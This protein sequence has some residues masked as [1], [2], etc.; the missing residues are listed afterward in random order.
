MG[1]LLAN[2]IRGINPLAKKGVLLLWAFLLSFVCVFGARDASAALAISDAWTNIAAETLATTAVNV[3]SS[4]VTVTAGVNRLLLV[5]LHMESGTTGVTA[6]VDSATF[7][8]VNL[9]PIDS[10]FARGTGRNLVWMGYLPDGSIPAGPQV[11]NFQ[12]SASANITGAQVKIASYTGVDQSSPITAYVNNTTTTTTTAFPAALSYAAGSFTVIAS[13]NSTASI[14]PSYS[15]TGGANFSVQ[16]GATSNLGGFSGNIAVSGA[17]ATAGSYATTTQVTYTGGGN[18]GTPLVAASINPYVASGDTTKPV[19]TSF[20]VP[21]SSSSLTISPITMSAS[22]DTGVVAYAITESATP[23]LPSAVTSPTTIT[24]YTASTGGTRVLYAWAKDGAGNVSDVYTSQACTINLPKKPARAVS[25]ASQYAAASYPAGTVSNFTVPAG[26]SRVLVVA[27]AATRTDIGSITVD[28]ITWGGK[29][30]TLAAGNGTQNPVWNHTFIYYL[31]EADIAA[32]SGN[33]LAVTISGGVAYYTRIY[34]SVYTGVDQTQPIDSAAFY[35]SASANSTVGPFL[36]TLTVSPQHQPIQIVNLAR[37]SVRTTSSTITSWAPGWTTAVAAPPGIVVSGPTQQVYV[38]E[39]AAT[40]ST[41]DDGSQHTASQNGTF[42]SYAAI[43]L[44]PAAGGMNISTGA[45]IGNKAVYTGDVNV[46]VDAFNIV[47]EA[48]DTIT[49]ITVTGSAATTSANVSALR[50]YR[51]TGSNLSIYEAGD[52]E[53]ASGTFSG[54]VASLTANEALAAGTARNYIIVYDITANAVPSISNT[55]TGYVSALAATN[56]SALTDPVASSAT[57]TIYPTTTI[58]N[59]VEPAAV[60]LYKASAPTN[61]DA[62]TLQHNGTTPTDDDNLSTV[63]ITLTPTGISGDGTVLSK[64]GKLEVV[65]EAG[66]VVYGSMTAATTGDIWN[67]P[68][69]GLTATSTPTNY[70][71]RIT[72][73]ANI[74]PGFY[75]VGGKI[76]SVVHSKGLSKLLNADTTSQTLT[77]DTEYPNNP[78]AFTAVTTPAAIQPGGKIDLAWT[79]AAVLDA[80]GGTLDATTPYIVKRAGTAPAEYCTDGTNVPVT[81]MSITDSGLNDTSAP[82]YHYRICAKDAQGNISNG[83][84]ASAASSFSNYCSNPPSITL[85]DEDPL[86]PGT[87]QDQLVKSVGGNPF[88]LQVT[89]NDVGECPNTTFNIALVETSTT[90]GTGIPAPSVD[91]FST[92]FPASVLLGKTAGPGGTNKTSET[93]SIYI[94]GLATADQIQKFKFKAQVTAAGHGSATSPF[95]TAVLNDMPPIVHNSNNMAKYQYGVWGNEYTCA[96]CHSNSTT[97]IKGV[98][99]VISTPIG[100]RNVVFDTISGTPATTGGYSNDLRASKD[101]SNNVCS[102]CHHRTRQ[103]Q[104]SAS[105]LFGGPANDAPYTTDHHNNRDCIKCHTHNTAFKSILGVC[106]DC[107]GFKGTDYSPVSKTTMV[108]VQTNALGTNPPSYGAHMAH[109]YAG[110]SCA[111]CHNNTNHGL[112]TDVWL[113]D[114]KLE[115]GFNVSNTTFPGFNPA[116]PVVGGTFEATT[117]L[118]YPYTWVAGPSTTINPVADYNASCTTYCHGNWS[119]NVGSG[120]KPN[121]VGTGQAACG[122]CHNATTVT[123]PV[124]GSHPTHSGTGALGL[125]KDCRICHGTYTQA[126]YTGAKHINGNVEWDLSAIS[127][128]AQYD[129]V[130]VGGSTGALAPTAPANYKT[131]TNMY[132]HSNV[133]GVGGVGAPTSYATPLW[134]DNGV[135]S[136]TVYCGS[137]HIYPNTVGGHAQHENEV[138]G[139]VCQVCHNIGGR[140]SPLNHA[141][142]KIDFEF[143]GLGQN[144]VYSKGSSVTPGLGYGTCSAS[145]CH[146]RYTRAWGPASA[147]SLCDKCHGSSTSAR[148][149]YNTKGPDGTLSIYSAAIGMHDIHIQNPNS[150]RKATFSR[151]TS[152]AAGMSCRQCHYQPDGPFYPGHMDNALPAEVPFAHVSSIAHVGDVFGYYSTPTYSFGAGTCSNV[153]CHGAGMAS[154]SSRGKYAGTTPGIVRSNPVWNQPILGTGDPCIKCHAMPPSAPDSS[155][156]HFNPGASRPFIASEC[157]NCHQHLNSTATGFVNKA[158]HINGVIDGGCTGCH[159]DPPADLGIGTETGLATPAQNALKLGTAGAHIA[160]MN[161]VNIQKNCYTCHYN[162]NPVMVKDGTG[163]LEIGFYGFGGKVKTGTFTG[164]T[165]TV[166]GPKWLANSAAGGTTTITKVDGVT[167]GQEA[168]V[169]SNLYCHGSFSGANGSSTSPNWENGSADTA[170]GSCHGASPA[171]IPLPALNGAHT[172][173]ASTNIALGSPGLGIACESCHGPS[174]A[175]MAHISGDVTWELDPNN[176]KI[177]SSAR[178]KDLAAGSTGAL[179]PSASYGSCTNFY[180]HSEVQGAGGIGLPTGGTAYKT[181]T[182]GTG[183]ALTCSSCHKDQVVTGTASHVNHTALYGGTASCGYCHHEAGD[184][185]ERHA[186][187]MI[188]VNIT[189]SKIG[190]GVYTGSNRD[191]GSAAGYG[192]CSNVI[193]HGAATITWGA[194]L[195]ANQCQKCHGS[196]SAAF[197]TV[198]SAQVAPGYGADGIATDGTTAASARRVG[199]HQRHLTTGVLSTNVKCS[200]CHVKVNTVLDSGHLNYTTATLTFSGRATGNGHTTAATSRD[201]NFTI[202]CSNLWCHT[203]KANS[204]STPVPVWTTTGMINETTLSVASCNVCHGFP[205]KTVGAGG[206]ALTFDHT[207]IAD[208]TTFPVSGCSCHANLSSTGTTYANIFSDKS[209]HLNGIIEALAGHIKKY[210]GATHMSNPAALDP[211]TNCSGCHTTWNAVGPYPAT[212]AGSAPSCRGCHTL[213]IL[214]T[215]ATSSCYDCHG[216]TATNAQPNGGVA[217]P[218]WS[219]SHTAHAALSYVCADCHLGGGTGAATHGNY[220]SAAKTRADVKV[221]FN[222]TKSGTAITYTAGTMTCGTSNCHGQKSP[223]WGEPIPAQQCRRCHGSQSVAYTGYTQATI[224]PGAGNFDTG[225]VTGNTVRGGVHQEHLTDSNGI[226]K[227]VRCVECHQTVAAVTDATHLNYTTATITF[228]GNAAAASHTPSRT[229]VSGVMNCSNVYCHQGARAE[230]TAAGQ[231]GFAS[232]PALTWNNA[233]LIDGTTVAGTCTNVCHQMPPGGAVVGDAHASLTANGTYTTPTSLQACNGCHPTINASIANMASIF[234]D[235]LKHIDGTVDGG[236]CSGCHGYDAASWATATQRATEG[237]GAHA[238]HVAYLVAK[239]GGTLNASGDQFGSGASWTNVCGVCHTGATH[240]TGEAI[241]GTARQINFQPGLSFGGSGPTYNGTVGSS[242]TV[243]SKVCFNT[244]CH[245]FTSPVWSTY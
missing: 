125:G 18:R 221:A 59:G 174:A 193:C 68:T 148:G 72:T 216:S 91:D 46:V 6:N 70:F 197:L 212:P 95:A 94:H 147:L 116:T 47:A 80:N 36:P 31:K 22:D 199:A 81:G 155:Y 50:I 187:H 23:P 107:H 223:A 236:S 67:I 127:A 226:G 185:T 7:G 103:H 89:N 97:N 146:G 194:N 141:N 10:T 8:G 104:Y 86:N 142:Q 38:R 154:N 209:Q 19:I 3:S 203:A 90:G 196:K 11:V 219:G 143:V 186:D 244:S 190:A 108:K 137:C 102:V 220:S 66:T 63:I 160:H 40:I 138:T 229:R 204:G 158:L 33:A 9:V 178:Y 245:Y 231:T 49:N 227:K 214:R 64:I 111:V 207:G 43:S 173:H 51:K 52:V 88:L 117:N 165:N 131:C 115:I 202:Q 153:W 243:K 14:T 85:G 162:Y 120:T 234:A 198:T 192:S 42:D 208:P 92:T 235:K 133:Q 34:A 200:E 75:T 128:V 71:L 167:P 166:N 112:A 32:A 39:R 238:K 139:F 119:G 53:I 28:S 232:R 161:N 145:D 25:W 189:T 121:W 55:L 83:I 201:G 98:F 114:D 37:S 62:F 144:T 181:V 105:K 240:T 134:G 237:K 79:A 100:K 163:K 61:L 230:G 228:S 180:C 44:K 135:D 129:G 113:G 150:P 54:N 124:S 58:G 188:Y 16:S 122:T 205:P 15:A 73:S 176:P 21:A 195:G 41:V 157:V 182:W 78:A 184:N 109:N 106:G 136:T 56:V 152:F 169:C 123:P 172:R 213:G 60:R 175:S 140:T 48:N 215:V 130:N 224:A 239:W 29:P 170:C 2:Q 183:T 191:A 164:Y 74:V 99:E 76:T 126:Q 149:F 241:G 4:S 171:S 30:L 96:T 57:I 82:I 17:N 222:T 65:N 206:T 77:I 1:K 45:T 118:N 87:I 84:T 159:G 20:T 211:A 177:G 5:T 242:S 217:F 132:C 35:E 12:A 27:I 110:M 210:P 225:R 156:T 218:N 24:S 69:V 13:S 151:F 26:A 233:S 101:G 168:N 179:A 93:V